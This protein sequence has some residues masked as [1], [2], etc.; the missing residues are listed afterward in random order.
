MNGDSE[1]GW[2]IAQVGDSAPPYQCEVTGETIA[3][4]C[5]A[6]GYENLAYLS[7]AAALEARLPGIIAPPAMLFVYAPLRR[8]DPRVARGHVD[9]VPAGQSRSE[10]VFVGVCLDFQG[11][12]VSPGDV[13]TSVTSVQDKFQRDGDR[14]LT[15]LVV[16]HNQRGD[17]VAQYRYTCRW[18][19]S[20]P[21]GAPT[22]GET[23]GASTCT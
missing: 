11:I 21:L 18:P 3:Q 2:E 10:P 4:F 16:A 23:A 9:P 1:Y 17:P 14:Y 12:L 13:I 20:G 8:P 19:D 7:Q 15:F 6:A 22:G 5:R